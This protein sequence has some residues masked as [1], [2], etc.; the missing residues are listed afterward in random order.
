M[1]RVGTAGG[2]ARLTVEREQKPGALGVLPV[3]RVDRAPQ[4]Q[5]TLFNFICD[6]GEVTRASEDMSHVFLRRKGV[7][8]LSRREQT[9]ARVRSGE[10]GHVPEVQIQRARR[11]CAK[12][13]P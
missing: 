11:V 12:R 10:G 8:L 3:N 1:Q 13:E 4:G 5:V 9:R 7:R 6:T 2:G